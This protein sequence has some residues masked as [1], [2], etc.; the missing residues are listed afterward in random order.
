[1]SG[2][3]FQFVAVFVTEDDLHP[4][5]YDVVRYVRGWR[6][7]HTSRTRSAPIDVVRSAGGGSS[8]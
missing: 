4:G 3:P 7:E 8:G 5:R 6:V 2:L 1:M